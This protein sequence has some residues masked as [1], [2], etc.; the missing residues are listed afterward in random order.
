MAKI[1]TA[2]ASVPALPSAL[3]QEE[4]EQCCNICNEEFGV[5]RADGSTEVASILP[6]SHIFGSICISRVRVLRAQLRHLSRFQ[7]LSLE[8]DRS[9]R[10][11][12]ILWRPHTY[13]AVFA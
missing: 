3:P 8:R 11:E 12:T 5:P 7:A 10:S 1:N 6:C 13:A 9:R 2:S 4:A